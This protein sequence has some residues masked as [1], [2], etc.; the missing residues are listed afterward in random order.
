MSSTDSTNGADITADQQECW[1]PNFANLDPSEEL[2]LLRARIAQL[3][4][5]QTIN[6]SPSSSASFDLVLQNEAE[7]QKAARLAKMEQYQNNQQHI[8]IDAWTQKLKVS[9]DQF[10]SKHQE[11]EKLLN[12]YQNLMEEMN[13]KQQQYQKET[14]DK[15]GWLNKDQEQCVSIDQFSSMQSDQKELL[16]RLDGF[17]QKQAANAEQQ[18]TDQKALSATIDQGMNQLKGELIAKMGQYQEEQQRKMEQYQKEQK[19]NIEDLQKTVAKFSLTPQNRWDSAACHR[20]LALSGPDR[21]IVQYNGK[22]RDGLSYRSVFAERPIPK[23]NLGI[24]YYEM[25]MLGKEGHVFIGFGRKQMQLNKWIGIYKGSYA[26]ESV[27]RFWG[28]AV[29]RCSRKNGRPYIEVGIPSFGVGDVIGCG[30]DLAT[31]QIIYTKNGQRLDTA[32]LFVDSAA[33]LF[34]CVSLLRSGDKIET[35]FGPDLEY[36]F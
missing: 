16:D 3:E 1:P 21:L 6:K 27:G 14:N 10:S 18:K 19:L 17:E 31:R 25:K 20:G 13:L 32:N 11:H 34:P 8:I 36:K 15:I 30:M 5:Q 22:D 23:K 9:T 4:R 29:E 26:Y 35:N 28:H 24:F 2:R 33:E 12:A 7:Q